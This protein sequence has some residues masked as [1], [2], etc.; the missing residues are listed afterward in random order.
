MNATKI[1]SLWY[2][3]C[4]LPLIPACA[5]NDPLFN[6]TGQAAFVPDKS[7][8]FTEYVQDSHENIE[9]VLNEIRP[10]NGDRTYLGGYTNAEAAAMRSPFQIPANE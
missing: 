1:K 3:L 5:S 2:H 9:Q 7:V 6:P 8:P 4:L 10:S